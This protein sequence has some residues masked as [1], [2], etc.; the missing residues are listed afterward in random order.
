[1]LLVLG[2]VPGTGVQGLEPHVAQGEVGVRV[3]LGLRVL[4][5]ALK[6][7]LPWTPLVFGQ[8]EVSN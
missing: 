1:M 8:V 3:T 6:L 2:A 5:D 4:Q 7:L